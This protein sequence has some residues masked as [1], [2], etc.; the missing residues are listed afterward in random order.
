MWIVVHM[1]NADPTIANSWC[2]RCYDCILLPPGQKSCK[3]PPQ[4]RVNLELWGWL[5]SGGRTPRGRQPGRTQCSTSRWRRH[6]GSTGGPREGGCPWPWSLTGRWMCP[7]ETPAGTGHHSKRGLIPAATECSSTTRFNIKTWVL[8]DYFLN[9]THL[10]GKQSMFE[11][12]GQ[13][14]LP[15]QTWNI[16]V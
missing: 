12:F 7:S 16:I 6:P 5:L 13:P 11:W 3:L 4:E 10:Q 8:K 15:L 1:L 2:A 9:M 14:V